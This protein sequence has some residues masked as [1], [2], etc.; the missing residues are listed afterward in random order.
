MGPDA[1]KPRL[2]GEVRE[3]R[4]GDSNADDEADKP[5]D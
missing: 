5:L 1:R 4:H 3:Y 2:E